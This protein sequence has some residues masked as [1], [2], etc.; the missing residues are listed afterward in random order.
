MAVRAAIS[1]SEPRPQGSGVTGELT[2]PARHRAAHAARSPF[3]MHTGE[4]RASALGFREPRA[5]T[6]QSRRAEGVSPRVHAFSE[7]PVAFSSRLR[8]S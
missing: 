5:S 8:F 4:P 1:N 2:L 3:S 6:L 7:K